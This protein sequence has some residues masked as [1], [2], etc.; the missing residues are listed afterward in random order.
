MD[1]SLQAPLLPPYP[2]VYYPQPSAPPMSAAYP[3]VYAQAGPAPYAPMQYAPMPPQPM[4]PAVMGRAPQTMTCPRC[5]AVMQTVVRH[6]AGFITF[7]AAAG[8]CIVGCVPCCLY[9]FCM[10]GCQDAIHTCPYCRT[11]IGSSKPF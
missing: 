9:P 2:P 5:M 11:V 10:E 8:L 6:E 1:P 3:P 7:A 4:H